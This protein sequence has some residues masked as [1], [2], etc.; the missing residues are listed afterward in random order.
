MDWT[1]LIT[2]L[3]FPIACCIAMAAGIWKVM[4]WLGQHIIVPLKVAAESHLKTSEETQVKLVD[5]GA[6][7][8]KC[9]GEMCAKQDEHLNICKESHGH[10][11]QHA[12]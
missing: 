8:V 6:K 9:I 5:Q 1:Q 3:G 11:S 2:Q 4:S 7:I 10:T 12:K